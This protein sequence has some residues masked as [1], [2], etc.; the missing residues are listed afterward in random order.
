MPFRSLGMGGVGVYPHP[1]RRPSRDNVLVRDMRDSDDED[2]HSAFF[3][4]EGLKNKEGEDAVLCRSRG[5][6][7]QAHSRCLDM[8]ARCARGRRRNAPGG[9]RISR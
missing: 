3:R 9:R 5:P 1:G 7:R 6:S 8:P 2:D 4:I